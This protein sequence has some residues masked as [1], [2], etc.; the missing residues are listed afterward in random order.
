MEPRKIFL[1]PVLN[2]ELAC[3]PTAVSKPSPSLF[4]V[5]SSTRII[6]LVSARFGR[7]A[8]S[9]EEAATF[10]SEEEAGVA[11]EEAATFAFFF[12]A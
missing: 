12:G 9:G 6:Q 4:K 3:I 2:S 10:V 8:E 1:A 7:G 5:R 11:D